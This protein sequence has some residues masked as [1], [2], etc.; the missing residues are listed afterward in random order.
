MGF[1]PRFKH[2]QGCRI[3]HLIR[4]AVPRSGSCDREG[5]VVE[6]RGRPRD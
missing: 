2:L 1:E 5:T 3:L 6:L 4:E